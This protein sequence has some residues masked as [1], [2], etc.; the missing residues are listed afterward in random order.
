MCVELFVWPSIDGL[1]VGLVSDRLAFSF[2][3][4]LCANICIAG[5]C[6]N[7]VRC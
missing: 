5:L 6:L 1:S 3:V 2:R 4:S 7:F